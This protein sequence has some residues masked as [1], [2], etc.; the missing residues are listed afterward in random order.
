MKNRKITIITLTLAVAMLLMLGVSLIQFNELNQELIQLEKVN[1]LLI[2]EK[3]ELKIKLASLEETNE[4]LAE[5][6]KE[7]NKWTSLGVFKITNYCSCREC[8]GKWT[9]YPTKLGTDY[10]EGRTIGVD[11][12][13]IP[14]GSEVKINGNVYIAEDTGSFKGKVI[15]IYV[16]DHSKFERKYLEIF[17]KEIKRWKLKKR[18]KELN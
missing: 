5:E 17:V 8:N 1:D 12:E 9:G 18:Y 10:V 11:P 15:D 2:E 4:R 16:N 6:N 3:N 14:L 7:L 13:I